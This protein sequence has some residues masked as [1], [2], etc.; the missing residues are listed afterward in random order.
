MHLY[1]VSL[2]RAASVKV[3]TTKILFMQV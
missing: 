3:I 1:P 2:K